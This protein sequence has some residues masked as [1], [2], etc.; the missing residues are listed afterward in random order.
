[1]LLEQSNMSKMRVNGGAAGW[2]GAGVF[3]D[4]SVEPI[5]NAHTS[6]AARLRDSNEKPCAFCIHIYESTAFSAGLEW[7]ARPLATQEQGEAPNLYFTV[8]FNLYFSNRRVFLL[9]VQAPAPIVHRLELRR[10][11][12]ESPS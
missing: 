2:A 10:A 5:N 9:V 7:I 4:Q 12:C 8:E 3:C 1:M 6:N 11:I